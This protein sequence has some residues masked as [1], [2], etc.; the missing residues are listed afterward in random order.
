VTAP[1]EVTNADLMRQLESIKAEI[2]RLGGTTETGE[3]TSTHDDRGAGAWIQWAA[4]RDAEASQLR[5]ASGD[6]PPLYRQPRD[7]PT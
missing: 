6:E 4:R 7:R 5:R 2:L 3:R 1:R